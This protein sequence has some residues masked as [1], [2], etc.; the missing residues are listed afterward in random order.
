MGAAFQ[1]SSSHFGRVEVESK[2]IAS[3]A[4]AGKVRVSAMAAT[5]TQKNAEY[6]TFAAEISEVIQEGNSSLEDV[7]TEQAS[8]QQEVSDH[9]FVQAFAD[10]E[11]EDR[12]ERYE[13]NM[14]VSVTRT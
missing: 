6:R 7:H 8:K 2:E 3:L 12:A 9:L 13:S 11:A 14:R 10:N 1:L 5:A 4:S